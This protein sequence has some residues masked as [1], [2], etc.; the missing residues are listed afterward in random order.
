MFTSELCIFNCK[1]RKNNWKE[2]F[3]KWTGG[4]YAANFVLFLYDTK[5]IFGMLYARFDSFTLFGI[6]K[7]QTSISSNLRS[8]INKE[9]GCSGSHC[10]G[11][12]SGNNTFRVNFIQD[13]DNFWWNCSLVIPPPRWK[14]TPAH[15]AISELTKGSEDEEMPLDVT[16]YGISTN[17]SPNYWV[18]WNID[19][20]MNSIVQV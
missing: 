15:V 2:N 9:R 5:R 19:Q 12:V 16:E 6:G 14:E 3:I 18:L 7:F 20:K 11:R 13:D 17:F 8:M 4:D 1:V 10:P